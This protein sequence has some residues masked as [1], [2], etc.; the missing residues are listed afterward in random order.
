MFANKTAPNTYSGTL[1]RTTGSYTWDG[2][3]F[4]G[5]SYVTTEA[6][7]GTLTFADRNNGA[8]SY[9]VDG[10]AQTKPIARQIFSD[11]PTVCN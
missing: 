8:F 10:S 4:F 11:V 3:G 5:S 6:G 9:S 1:Y 7:S 2:S